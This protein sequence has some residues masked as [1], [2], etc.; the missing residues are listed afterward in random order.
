MSYRSDLDALVARHA[1]LEG[2]ADAAAKRRDEAR[3]LLEE[4][5][6][7]E[8]APVLANLR[9][10]S[11]CRESWAA[12]P[13]DDR[14][15][16]CGKCQQ[17][18]YN[19]S[20]MTCEEAEA[21]IESRNGRLCVRYF[22]RF[23]GTILLADCEIGARSKRKRRLIAA[24]IAASLASGV[25]AYAARDPVEPDRAEPH[26]DG[27]Y[28]QGDPVPP[29]PPDSDAVMGDMGIMG[30]MVGKPDP[31]LSPLVDVPERPPAPPHVPL[32]L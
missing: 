5:R 18:V 17:N 28:H 12:M 14:V 23:D 16:E 4:A 29:P 7:R 1:A 10:A 9:V 13:G 26:S 15:R 11:P 20:A 27:S 25:G 3:Q 19:L 24:G 32:K 22:Q 6:E 21:L 8:Q 31:A 30:G 2:E